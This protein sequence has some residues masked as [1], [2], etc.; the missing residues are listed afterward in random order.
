MAGSLRSLLRRRRKVNVCIAMT[1]QHRHP[2][3]EQ[4]LFLSLSC[5]QCGL[6]SITAHPLALVVSIHAVVNAYYCYWQAVLV[7]CLPYF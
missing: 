4:S 1:E 5:R 7:A 3:L 2:P 6:K